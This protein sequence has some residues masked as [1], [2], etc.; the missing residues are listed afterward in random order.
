[1]S[2]ALQYLISRHFKQCVIIPEAIFETNTSSVKGLLN[3]QITR[4]MNMLFFS[5]PLHLTISVQLS[6]TTYSKTFFEQPLKSSQTNPILNQSLD[7]T[8]LIIGH[9]TALGSEILVALVYPVWNVFKI[10]NCTAYSYESQPARSQIRRHNNAASKTVVYLYTEQNV[11]TRS[12]YKTRSGWKRTQLTVCSGWMIRV[13]LKA[14]LNPL[15][16]LPRV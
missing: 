11:T 10:V 2:V 15:T 12:I 1:M 3:W 13:S 6:H 4:S 8:I 9:N 5:Q 7:I 16:A 14:A